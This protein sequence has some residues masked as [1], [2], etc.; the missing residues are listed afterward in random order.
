MSAPL[1]HAVLKSER[2]CLYGSF[3]CCVFVFIRQLRVFVFV[4]LQHGETALHTSVWHGFPLLAQLLIAA[5]ADTDTVN[6]V[7]Y[8]P[9]PL[10]CRR[11]GYRHGQPGNVPTH[12]TDVPPGQTSTQSS[13]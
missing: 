9:T 4:L 11:G 2:L 10:R 3:E 7:T 6:Q 1:P 8:P 12:P 13:R 5:G